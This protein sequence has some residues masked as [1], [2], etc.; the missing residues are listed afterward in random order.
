MV[1]VDY[2]VAAAESTAGAAEHTAGHTA[3]IAGH[4]AGAAAVHSVANIG[5][6]RTPQEPDSV[7]ATVMPSDMLGHFGPRLA[8]EIDVLNLVPSA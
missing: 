2:N 4:T 1:V 8:T 6:S 7:A 3:G 5:C